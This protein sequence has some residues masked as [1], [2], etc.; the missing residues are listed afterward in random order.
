TASC[1]TSV[2]QGYNTYAIRLSDGLVVSDEQNLYTLKSSLLSSPI[3]N[4]TPPLPTSL[5]VDGDG[6][7]EA[8]YV[9]TLEGKIRKYTLTAQGVTAPT[10][11]VFGTGSS[12][13][14]NVFD[15]NGSKVG[16]CTSGIACQPIGVSPTVVRNNSGDLDVVVATGGADWARTTTDKSDL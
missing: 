2:T 6:T 10:L 3:P 1:P 9:S 5:D 4:D 7:D 14:L 16:N 15:A 11:S 12:A 8:V 13:P